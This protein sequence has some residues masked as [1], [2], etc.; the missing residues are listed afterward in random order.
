MLIVD[1]LIWQL[2]LEKNFRIRKKSTLCDKLKTP[3]IYDFSLF[4]PHSTGIE[5]YFPTRIQ[6]P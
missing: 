5:T 3:Y 4:R 6:I 1:W 2:S